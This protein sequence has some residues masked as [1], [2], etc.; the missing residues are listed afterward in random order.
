MSGNALSIATLDLTDRRP[1]IAFPLDIPIERQL[2]ILS[3]EI[4]NAWSLIIH[5]SEQSAAW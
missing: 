1:L 2:A 3:N 5:C 4:Y